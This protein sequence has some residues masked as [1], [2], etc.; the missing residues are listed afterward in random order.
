[1]RFPLGLQGGDVTCVRRPGPFGMVGADLQAEEL[2]NG[3]FQGQTGPHV[4]P[5]AQQSGREL[6]SQLAHPHAIVEGHRPHKDVEGRDEALQNGQMFLLP[7]ED[8]DAG[9]KAAHGYP[10]TA[11]RSRFLLGQQRF[12]E[13]S[14]ERV[15]EALGLRAAAVHQRVDDSAHQDTVYRLGRRQEQATV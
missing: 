7:E 11:Q 6:L 2:H 9:L 12:G 15:V 14:E 10:A 5:D 8:T 3:V 1:M 13:K 4:G